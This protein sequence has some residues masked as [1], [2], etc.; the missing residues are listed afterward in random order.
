MR[1]SKPI[2]ATCMVYSAVGQ[3]NSWQDNF[4]FVRDSRLQ[5]VQL[6]LRNYLQSSEAL[7][8]SMRSG[9]RSDASALLEMITPMSVQTAAIVVAT[10]PVL[11]VY[12]FAQKYFTK[13][14]MMGAI[15]G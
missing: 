15:K 8:Q 5:T 7:A 9:M 4:F 1:L 10:V 14:I 12:P 11:F 3:W 2:I 13:G 6:I